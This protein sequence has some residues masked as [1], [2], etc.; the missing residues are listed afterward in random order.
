MLQSALAYSHR[1]R[2]KRYASTNL[3]ECLDT[4][5]PAVPTDPV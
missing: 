2:P 4:Q 1:I 3:L 5:P